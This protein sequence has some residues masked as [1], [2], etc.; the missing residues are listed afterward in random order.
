MVNLK[1]YLENYFE[2]QDDELDFVNYSNHFKDAPCNIYIIGSRPRI[3]VDKDYLVYNNSNNEIELLFK[4]QTG[5]N[6]LE[7]KGKLILDREVKGSLSL[8]TNFPNS[9]FNIKDDL[10]YFFHDTEYQSKKDLKL[11]ASYSLR[12][13]KTDFDKNLINDF[14]TLYIGQSIKMNKNL[15]PVK[16]L[17]SHSNFQRVLSKCVSE[18]VDKEI[19]ILLCSFVGK[20]DLIA[21]ADNLREV[22]NI[23]DFLHKLSNESS[24]LNSN[25]KLL[26]D[27][28][29]AALID[30]FDTRNFNSDFI[31]S[32]GKKTHGYFKSLSSSIVDK[33]IVEIDLNNLCRIYSDSI[34]KKK[35]H[36]IIYDIKENFKRDFFTIEV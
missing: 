29:E 11:K 16:R 1:I 30:Y 17:K 21:D 35:H 10:G 12:V 6:F 14:N 22:G 23:N 20:V 18:Y 26:T 28:V 31:G 7:T 3:T 9:R 32:F 34:E 33:L 24:I 25:T 13:S 2:A 5:F 15:S 4:I 19:Y 8:E 27:I 36:G